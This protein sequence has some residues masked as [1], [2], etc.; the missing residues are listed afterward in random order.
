MF[1]RILVPVDGDD[2]PDRA[3]QAALYV[4]SRFGASIT[5]FLVE[6][7]VQSPLRP[8]G[9]RLVQG[10]QDW[11]ERASME[12]D[13]SAMARLARMTESAGVAFDTFYV[14]GG[15]SGQEV[16][17]ASQTSGCDLILMASQGQGAFGEF[18][19]GSET[20]AILAQSQLSMMIVK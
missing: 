18:L 11:Q 19:F 8:K 2:L 3:V 13:Q 17:R 14:P 20:R 6:A 1:K 12:G 4:A 16:L 5:G 10:D 9:L 7:S 15:H